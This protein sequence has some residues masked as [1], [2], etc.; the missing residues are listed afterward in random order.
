[1]IRGPRTDSK[2]AKIVGEKDPFAFGSK[3]YGLWRR[4]MSHIAKILHQEQGTKSNFGSYCFPGLQK[5]VACVLGGSS[6]PI[7]H[8]DG[9]S[10]D[11]N[12]IEKKIGNILTYF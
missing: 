3:N 9:S 2:A 6:P 7:L 1:M 4:L 10:D 12:H 11:K 5:G 8:D